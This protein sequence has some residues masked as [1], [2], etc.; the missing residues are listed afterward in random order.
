[1]RDRRPRLWRRDAATPIVPRGS[2]AGRSLTAVVAIMTFLAALTTG[3]VMMVVSA[4]KRLA[5]GGRA[6]GHHPGSAGVRPRHRSGCAHRRRGG[7]RHCR[8]RR[9]ARL[10]RR[11]IGT[12]GRT[13]AR[14]RSAARRAADPAHDRRQARV[15][16][17]HRIFPAC[18]RHLPHGCPA[19]ASTITVAGWIACAPWRKPRSWSASRFWRWSSS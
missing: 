11:G 1:M 9:R 19:P 10:Q 13:V 3:A 15:R 8:H 12:A 5:V 17:R 14:L 6:R 16:R 2:I 18:A 4:G 7:A